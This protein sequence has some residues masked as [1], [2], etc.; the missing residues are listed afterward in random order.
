M[1][2]FVVVA[3][4]WLA[5]ATA[6]SAAPL[7]LYG[8]LPAVEQLEIS[9]DGEM[10]AMILTNGE[11]RMLVIS[12]LSD[13]TPIVTAP[14]GQVKI[15]DIAWAGQKDLLITASQTAMALDV[16]GPRREWFMPF[17]FNLEERR[18]RPLLKDI[19]ETSM[20][21][22]ND[23][24]VVRIV[25]GKPTVFLT[26]VSFPAN[27]GILTV[28]KADLKTKRVTVD[29]VGTRDTRDWLVGPDGKV[30]AQV[31]YD[32]KTGR[33]ALKVKRDGAGWRE[34]GVIDAPYERPSL[35]GLGRDGRSAVLRVGLAEGVSAL[36]E[37]AIADGSWGE[38][39]A[40]QDTLGGIFD[41]G[42]GRLI[43]YAALVGEDARYTFFDPQ[44][45]K[46]WA[47]VAR[48]FPDQRVRLESWSADRRRIVVKVDSPTEGPADALVD[49]A[50]KKATWLGQP[51]RGLEAGDVAPVR[52]IRFKAADGL[53]LTG[54][55][56]T[57]AGKAVKNLPL[58]VFPHGGPQARDTLGFDWWA[59]AMASRGYAVL[60]V[61]YRGSSGFGWA[62]TKA[63]F[64]EWGRKMQTDLSDGVRY[65]SGEGL[66]DP[67]RV[68]I[69][70]AS[71]GGYAALAGATLDGGVYR[72]AA[73][74]GGLSDLRR[75]LTYSRTMGG[76]SAQRYWNRFIGSDDVNDPVLARYSP[77]RLA[78]RVD[79]PVLLVHGRDDTVV[80]LEQSQLMADA[81]KKAGK[82]VEL[83]VLKGEDHWLSTGETRLA[84]LQAVVAF[85][86]KNNPPN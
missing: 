30:L 41:P 8:R 38:P 85:L 83:V 54:Y 44:E 86:E 21:T 80:R 17:V 42:D 43:G 19:K 74:F 20:N 73:S 31:V 14:V 11:D 49:L 37:V 70:G 18:V 29:T 25:D 15:R 4:A 67:K 78:D 36:R 12:R 26:G 68:C 35:V 60:Q 40:Q 9:P 13:N 55:L 27:Y 28:F 65:L 56:T 34:T 71:Y 82:P 45:Q 72:C 66:I 69:V 57:P 61:N 47:S 3:L 5:L 77:V 23:V 48:A 64:G 51:Y 22:I 24:P 50:A 10:L 63:G 62:F 79:I 2:S 53:P 6:A 33:W 39:F 81:L 59:Q 1:R 84:M 76:E 75:H 32:D 7:E 46:A 52:A 16:T 58:I